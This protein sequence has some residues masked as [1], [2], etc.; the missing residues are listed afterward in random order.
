[1]FWLMVL[2]HLDFSGG[3]GWGWWIS[4]RQPSLGCAQAGWDV[5]APFH[6][7]SK[8]KLKYIPGRWNYT[9]YG[10]ESIINCKLQ[11][12]SS[13]HTY[14]LFAL[15]PR[16]R[17]AVKATTLAGQ[18]PWL[19]RTTS[20]KKHYPKIGGRCGQCSVKI[21]STKGEWQWPGSL[22]HCPV[23]ISER[24]VMHSASVTDS[25]VAARI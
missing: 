13:W 17:G 18:C 8:M 7:S 1:M 10:A 20:L 24:D 15:P 5:G 25:V 2:L 3:W 6:S 9:R 22:W 4:A 11:L 12:L 23:S 21:E 19:C 14:F 16:L